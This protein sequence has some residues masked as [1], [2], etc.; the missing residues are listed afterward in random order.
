MG[1]INAG[2]PSLVLLSKYEGICEYT[3]W[4]I[5]QRMA[6]LKVPT[7]GMQNLFL[8]FKRV[9]R[10]TG[11]I[12]GILAANNFQSSLEHVFGESLSWR[13]LLP[14]Q[15][16]GSG[17]PL[18]PS[19]FDANACEA[20]A[21]LA[22]ELEKECAAASADAQKQKETE[23]EQCKQEEI[24]L[25]RVDAMVANAQRMTLEAESKV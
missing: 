6:A 1:K 2:W 19:V 22:I 8:A 17:D 7:E 9:K 11:G 21:A 13:W 10:R 23:Q 12:R 16:G 15:S 5:T 4:M 3:E 18:R 14:L 25:Q 20:W 24:W